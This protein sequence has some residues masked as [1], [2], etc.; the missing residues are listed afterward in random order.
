MR[1]GL[2]DVDGHN[3]PNLALMKIS[4]YHKAKGDSTEWAIPMLKY[5]IVYQSK[6]FD[7]SPDENTCIDCKNLIRGGSGYDL[8]NKLPAEIET[9]YPDYSLYGETKAY[10]FLTR[11][12]PRNCPYCIVGRK[13]GLKSYQV[14]DLRQF[15]NGQSEIVLCDP[16]ILACKNRIELLQQLIDNKAWIDINQGLDIRFMTDDAIDKIKQLKLKMLH[17]AWD[18]D[19]DTDLILRNLEAF[20]KATDFD[21]RKLRVYVLTN[22]ETEFDFDIYRVY[23]LKEMG[24]D[25]FIMIYD[26]DKFVDRRGKLKPM[27]ILLKTY[28]YEEIKHFKKCHRLQRKVDNKFIWHSGE[29]ETEQAMRKSIK[30]L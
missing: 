12:C 11:G 24:Y 7:F 28:T 4:A 15:W 19:K 29:L 18:R 13:E 1:I 17:F 26:K 16:N 9:I 3:F 14:A 30:I 20:K 6:V 21:F 23:K 25:P 5:N 22:Y 10:G 2:I 8:E 27:E